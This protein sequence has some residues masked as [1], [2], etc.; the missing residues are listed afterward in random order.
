MLDYKNRAITLL[1]KSVKKGGYMINTM[2]IILG[3]LLIDGDQEAKAQAL[4]STINQ[5]SQAPDE[6]KFIA[7]VLGE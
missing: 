3:Q 2:K 6:A 7:N 4:L 1:Q 5:D